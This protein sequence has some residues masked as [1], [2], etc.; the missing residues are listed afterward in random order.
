MGFIEYNTEDQRLPLNNVIEPR[1]KI[2]IYEE[3]T[4][5]FIDTITGGITGGSLSITADSDIRWTFSLTV[6]PNRQWDIRIKEY[7]YVWIDKKCKLYLGLYDRIRD[8]IPNWYPCG[9][10]IFTATS[11]QYD[12]TNNTLSISCSDKVSNLNG[13]RNGEYGALNTV[14][15]AYYD[16]KYYSDEVNYDEATKAYSCT[17][18]DYEEQ[19]YFTGDI[20]CLRI[21]VDNEEGC[22]ININNLG[23]LHIYQSIVGYDIPAG[24]ILAD[25]DFMGEFVGEYLF[26]VM[27]NPRTDTKYFTMVGKKDD[28]NIVDE[29]GDAETLFH[30][31]HNRIRDNVITVLRQ[32]ARISEDDYFVDDIG[33]Y[34]AMP[35]YHGYTSYR[36]KT[37]F[38]NAV[39]FDQEFGVGSN[40]WQI[41]TAYRDLYPNYE[42]YFDKNGTFY[43]Q[44]IP[45]CSNDP[46]NFYN[47]YIQKILISENTSNDMSAVRN[48]NL[49]YGKA[50]ETDFYAE[51]NI[52]FDAQHGIYNAIVTG[53]ED[54][55]YNGD[56][57]ALKIPE[58]NTGQFYI[59][60]APDEKTMKKYKQNKDPYKA[61]VL[62]YND[63]DEKPVAYDVDQII[64]A[65]S[66]GEITEYKYKAEMAQRVLE[67]GAIYVFK[68]KK[69]REQGKTKVQ[70]YLLGHFQAAGLCALVNGETNEEMYTTFDGTQVPVYSEDYFKDVYNV[71]TV[72]LV[73]IPDSPF[74]CEKLGV[75]LHVHSGGE[76]ENIDSNADAIE[77][78]KW[79]TYK[80]ARLTDSISI[81]TKLVPFVNDVNFKIQYIKSDEEV[82]KEFLVKGISHDFY[83]GTSTWNLIQFYDYYIPET[84]YDAYTWEAVS[85]YNW[86]ELKTRFVWGILNGTIEG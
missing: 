12:A 58:S 59:R 28:E 76:F 57:I 66:E 33:E 49:V 85:L 26:Q 56:K 11:W 80:S 19:E 6:I 22:T 3:L 42:A 18:S 37:P 65:Y 36:D 23:A 5:V 83:G 84:N 4:D 1:I 70:A 72:S 69:K 13:S 77:R 61:A 29:D 52:E 79:E 46:I 67:K 40:I 20:F 41:I 73:A 24:S 62:V 68:I 86:T 47:D 63:N 44:M 31:T 25:A 27:Y 38:W 75:R 32:L 8:V 14:F 21:P 60:I 45:D 9:E 48:V 78:A 82:P 15:P 30:I 39:P 74:T 51:Q 53:Y 54:G 81:T 34:K 43:M 50:I 2:D 64:E 55:Y 17:I 35:G 16:T 71:E 10:Y 7:N